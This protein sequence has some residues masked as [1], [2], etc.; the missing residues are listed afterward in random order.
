MW[1]QSERGYI[2]LEVSLALLILSG[3]A[4]VCAAVIAAYETERDIRH[5][6]KAAAEYLTEKS[7]FDVQSRGIAYVEGVN[8]VIEQQEAHPFTEVCLQGGDSGREIRVCKYYYK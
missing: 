8:L 6:E 2:M 4:L 5:L 1:K 3:A 7:L